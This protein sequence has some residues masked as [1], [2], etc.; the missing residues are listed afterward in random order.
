LAPF[1]EWFGSLAG[2]RRRAVPKDLELY[3]NYMVLS[4]LPFSRI[5]LTSVPFCFLVLHY[6]VRIFTCLL[7]VL[8]NNL[9][10]CNASA[11]SLRKLGLHILSNLSS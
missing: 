8:S 11:H 10:V 2:E 6:K 7:R 3:K 4:H 9:R 5:L 1:R